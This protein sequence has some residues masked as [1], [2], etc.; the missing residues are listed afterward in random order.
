[1]SKAAGARRITTDWDAVDAYRPAATPGESRWTSPWRVW[2][3]GHEGLRR[4]VEEELYLILGI[5][6]GVLQRQAFGL[7]PPPCRQMP[8]HRLA[9]LGRKQ[10]VAVQAQEVP[11][12]GVVGDC[13]DVLAVL[14][15]GSL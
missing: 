8:P 7:V 9:N 12:V 10:D 6:G 15:H 13:L 3:L 4:G 11:V 5:G 14:P 1:M 2:I